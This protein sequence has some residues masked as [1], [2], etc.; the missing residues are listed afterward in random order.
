MFKRSTVKLLFRITV[1]N[2]RCGLFGHLDMF[3]DG[4]GLS[5]MDNFMDVFGIGS[6][7]FLFRHRVSDV[8]ADLLI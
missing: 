2:F 6:Q 4:L 1:I 5:I 8:F 3:V 7:D